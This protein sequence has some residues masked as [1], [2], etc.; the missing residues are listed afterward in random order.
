MKVLFCTDGSKI[1]FGALRNFAGWNKNAVVDVIS[2]IDWSFLPNDISI[3]AEGFSIRCANIADNILEYSEK[4]ID[5]YGLTFGEKIKH[6]GSAVEGIIEELEKTHY[7]LVLMGSHGKK[8]IQKWLGSVSRDIVYNSGHS[9]FISKNENHMERI[10]FTTDGSE[11]SDFAIN[12]ALENLNLEGK[13]IYI[14]AVNENPDLL[15]L[16]GTLDTNWLIAIEQQ[17][18]IHSQKALG[19]LK[20]RI[21]ESGYTVHKSMILEGNPSQKII[22][23]AKDEK[24]DLIILGSKDQTKMQ[25]FLL[26]SVSKR[27]LE[28]THSDV[29]IF[30]G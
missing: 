11:I 24:I 13:E 4:E 27:V 28:N 10:L 15:F 8:G 20:K 14:C 23:Y 6:C 2:V 9:T 19:N 18:Q 29:L 3:E 21:E 1:S 16:D 17:Q 7:D 26:G 30:K 5:K 25:K 22:D 12:K